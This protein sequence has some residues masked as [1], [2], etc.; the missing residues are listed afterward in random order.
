MTIETILLDSGMGLLLL[1]SLSLFYELTVI[2]YVMLYVHILVIGCLVGIIINFWEVI[3][4]F[5]VNPLVILGYI[6]PFTVEFLFS[7]IIVEIASLFQEN[8][9]FED[10][11][12]ITITPMMILCLPMLFPDLQKFIPSQAKYNIYTNCNILGLLCNTIILFYGGLF[13]LNLLKPLLL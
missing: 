5:L 2:F 12:L 13:G 10:V 8:L 11:F 6:I 4:E 3:F 1:I 9:K 7:A